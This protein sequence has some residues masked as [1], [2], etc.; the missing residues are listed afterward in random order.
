MSCPRHEGTM[1]VPDCVLNRQHLVAELS[2]TDAVWGQRT[3]PGAAHRRGT[4]N[5]LPLDLRM[6]LNV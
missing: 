2:E 5:L 4:S 3:T 1:D 6:V